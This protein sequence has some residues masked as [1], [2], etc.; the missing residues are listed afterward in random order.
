MP[1]LVRRDRLPDPHAWVDGA[2]FAAHLR[3]LAAATGFPAAWLAVHADLPVTLAARL[4]GE[5]GERPLRRLPRHL[6][7]RLIALDAAGVGL[8]ARASVP[9]GRVAECLTAL[10][11]RGCDLGALAA[12]LGTTVA[13]LEATAEGRV[14]FVPRPW[15]WASIATLALSDADVLV[16]AEAA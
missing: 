1:V 8:A 14:G 5:A 10:R 2:P 16:A 7:A 9:A 11:E 6:A 13:L 4:L 3:V 15:L 12:R